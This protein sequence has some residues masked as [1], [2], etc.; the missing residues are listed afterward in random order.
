VPQDVRVGSASVRRNNGGVYE[1]EA[2]DVKL[3]ATIDAE[4]RLLRLT[5]PDA[6]VVVER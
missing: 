4:G 1:L 5:V 3:Q 2:G 6:K